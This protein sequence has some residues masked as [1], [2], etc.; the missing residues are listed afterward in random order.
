MP[1][2][3]AD[4]DA[5]MCTVAHSAKVGFHHMNASKPQ[6]TNVQKTKASQMDRLSDTMR[7]HLL[8]L[9]PSCVLLASVV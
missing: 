4:L 9:L 5:M 1:A 8:E 2:M 7:S 6:A 3:A